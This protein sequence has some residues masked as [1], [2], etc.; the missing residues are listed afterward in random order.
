MHAS[1]ISSAAAA[2]GRPDLPNDVRAELVDGLYAPLGSLVIGA[3]AG[4]F[5]GIVVSLQT[6]NPWL[7]AS[8]LALALVAAGRATLALA[9]RRRGAGAA[10][11]AAALR[12]WERR[13]A[14]GA[15]SYAACLGGLCFNSFW[16]SDDAATHLIVAAITTGYAAGVTGRNA[17]LPRI[18][19]GQLALTIVPLALGAALRA[20]PVYL[21]LALITVLYLFA[22]VEIALF[23]ARNHLR[24]LLTTR[25]KSEL[26]RSLAAQNLR[27]DAALGNMP[28]GLCML[29]A[30]R[31]LVVWNERFCDI[32]GMD[33]R[34]VR[35]GVSI[36]ELVAHNIALG[37]WA[38]RPAREIA[39]EYRARLDS[40]VPSRSITRLRNDRTVAL[41]Q[42]PMA[43]G[44]A[45]VIFEDVTERERAAAR[46]AHMARHDAL[47]DLPNRTLMLETL[48]VWSSQLRPAAAGFAVLCLDLD[49][50]KA[51]NDT[52]GHA[53]GDVLLQALAGRL[54]GSLGGDA[55]I[56]RVGGDEF[57]VLL[58]GAGAA[59]AMEQGRTLI[60]ALTAPYD[61]DGHQVDIGVSIG[62]A[63]APDHGEDPDEL[64]KHAD[65]ALYRAKAEGRGTIRLFA[66]DM[67]RRHQDRRRLESEL[68]EAVAGGAFALLYQPRIDL[69]TGQV[70][71]LAA[72]LHWRHPTRGVVPRADFAA[73]AEH[74]GLSVPI[75]E[76]MLHQAC[77][78]A[79][80]WPA[81]TSVCVSLSPAQ[82]RGGSVVAS[83]MQAVAASGLPPQR[84]ELEITEAAFQ[85]DGE[86]AMRVLRE[87]RALGLRLAID[88]FGA[89]QTSLGQLRAFPFDRIRIDRSL[90]ADIGTGE[91]SAAIV[92]AIAGLGA[93]LGMA[94]SADG[95]T[96]AEQLDA[97]RG[98]GCSEAQGPMLGPPLAAAE[99]AP[100]LARMAADPPADPSR[101]PQPRAAPAGL[102]RAMR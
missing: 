76:W 25:E 28:H 34:V 10:R 21:A 80:A 23:L 94:I 84:L 30:D 101:A 92:Q 14:A 15:W 48:A 33:R 51:V 12:D 66:A 38:S 70:T 46:I 37:H 87:L 54:R 91:A 78:D 52:L 3:V 35:A 40:G 86:A 9:Y 59:R 67:D 56:A 22:T 73:V 96:T 99:I 60:A 39:A 100:L 90:V 4:I 11:D 58:P 47:T 2:S 45:V 41:S 102:K 19:I 93:S 72:L 62:A 97:V 36:E 64:L 31:R 69:V 27:F 82:L 85:R 43:D 26:A 44:G 63:L 7:A 16:V 17:G 98:G 57:V 65:L 50:F 88:D 55:V 74:T 89:R 6:G 71:G 32:Y 24:L 61:L 42:Q 18:G 83:V 20:E 13:Y 49:R 1:K 29:D 81:A 5:V 77:R 53:I 8:T 75:G 68:R 95:V 79:A